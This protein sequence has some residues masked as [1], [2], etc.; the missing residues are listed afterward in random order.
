MTKKDI[1]KNLILFP[2]EIW[3]KIVCR[4]PFFIKDDRK[5]IEF[6]W[7]HRMDYPLNL[8]NPRTF[9][10]KL[11]WLKLYDRRDIYT[12]LVDK[13]EVKKYVASIIGDQYIIPTIGIWDSVEDINFDELPNQ[14]VLK[15]THS[16]GGMAIC[17]DKTTFDFNK[18]KKKLSKSIKNDYY[19]LGREWPYKNVKRRII[20]EPYL[21]D[22]KTKELRDYKFF[23][24]SGFPKLMF[25]ATDRQNRE[26]PY[27][28]FYDM[29]FNHINL[30]HGHPNAP[31]PPSRP[32][33][34]ELMKQLATTLSME[35]IEARID[36]YEAN[37]NVYF[38][39]ITLFHHNGT[40]MFDPMEW[41]TTLGSYIK[42]PSY[43]K[44]NN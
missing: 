35:L 27:F 12:T 6:I 25:I 37:G 44:P 14:F 4:F 29:D 28:D 26:E 30:R 18:A 33:N 19:M 13:L 11:Q 40:V 20:A 7:K 5:Y 36:F 3:Y 41:D 9:N 17:K 43:M 2:S 15:T 31:V 16:S 23:C 21:E 24:F 42:I 39:E 10:E 32:D 8:D 34:F 22:F 38:G 1:L